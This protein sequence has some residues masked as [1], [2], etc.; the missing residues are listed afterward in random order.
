MILI[1]FYPDCDYQTLNKQLVCKKTGENI[2]TLG[3][4][5]LKHI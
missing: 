5:L 1:Y 2:D 4:V 3:R